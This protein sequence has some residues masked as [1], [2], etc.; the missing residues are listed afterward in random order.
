[1]AFIDLAKVAMLEPK[2]H[3]NESE[4]LKDLE[5]YS[6]LDSLEEA[7]Y[8]NLTA[9]AA[10]ICGTSISLVSLI[11]DHRQWFKSHHGLDATET[12][13]KHAFCAH[14]INDPDHLFMIQDARLDDRFRDNPL[15]TGDPHVIFYAG[16]PLISEEGYPLG[17]LCV[18]DDKPKVLNQNQIDALTSLANQVMNL[19]KLRKKQQTLEQMVV[20]LEEKNK[21]LE[22]FAVIA[23]HDLRSPLSNI[24]MITS[25]FT[26][27]YFS[28][29][30]DEG[31]NMLKLIG[32]SSDK[33]RSLI[34]GLLAYSKSEKVL[35]EMKTKISTV[36]LEHDIFD[37]FKTDDHLEMTF[38]TDLKEITVNKTAINQILFNLFTNAIKYND[39]DMSNIEIGLLDLDKHYQFYVQDNG[40][41]IDERFHGKI[42][43]IFETIASTDKYGRPGNGIGLATVKKIVEKSGGSIW[44]ESELGK[45]S[46]FIF[47]IEK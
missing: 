6:I 24:S 15:V 28:Q 9:I 18:I 41:G 21:E 33:L 27:R 30:G 35:K 13:K 47:T 11:D 31:K 43:D 4:R 42:F 37:S 22:R 23:A 14:A 7:D 25:L 46:K 17:T 16:M 40:L 8:D 45:G 12:P 19:M 39:K 26:E 36:D 1:M 3:P 34:D 10:Q 32:D 38:K 2:D 29:I 44:V 20:K 5:S